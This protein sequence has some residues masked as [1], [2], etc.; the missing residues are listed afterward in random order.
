MSCPRPLESEE[1]VNDKGLPC[2][3]RTAKECVHVS[4]VL[5]SL[6]MLGLNQ[7]SLLD[8]KSVIVLYARLSLIE[9]NLL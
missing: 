8:D 7:F 1:L 5:E 4:L 6:G 2:G 3:L 9:Q